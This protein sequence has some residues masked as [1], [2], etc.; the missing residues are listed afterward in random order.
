M[1]RLSHRI[2]RLDNHGSAIWSG[3][4]DIV[5]SNGAVFNNLSGASFDAQGSASFPGRAGRKKADPRE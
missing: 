3:S 5:G 1:G 2:N 4:Y